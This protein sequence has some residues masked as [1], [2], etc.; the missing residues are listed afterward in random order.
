MAEAIVDVID[1]GLALVEHRQQH[2][3]DFPVRSFVVGADVVDLTDLAL[4][5]HQI[6]D[7]AIRS[8]PAFAAEYG[9]RGPSGSVSTNDPSSIEP[10]TSSVEI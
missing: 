5:Q 3:G 4:T 8:D 9:E 7:S 10:Y 6:Y 1:I 2:V